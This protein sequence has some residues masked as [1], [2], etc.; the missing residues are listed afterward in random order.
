MEFKKAPRGMEE[1][2]SIVQILSKQINGRVPFVVV[3]GVTRPGHAVAALEEGADIV[4]MGRQALVDPEWTEK[5]KQGNEADINETIPQELVGKLDIPETMWNA[6]T[7]YGMV[8]V[9]A[10]V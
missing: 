2:D 5:V 9:D 4:V 3:G 7:S 10:K 6:I 8:K 1:G